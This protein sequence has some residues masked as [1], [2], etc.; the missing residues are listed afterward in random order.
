MKQEVQN[1]GEEERR[2]CRQHGVVEGEICD[3]RAPA[4]VKGKVHKRLVVYDLK[5]ELEAEL[6]V[7]EP[8]KLRFLFGRMDRIRYKYII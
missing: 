8:K 6:E 1:R 5:E 2:E 7:A 3:R 4:R